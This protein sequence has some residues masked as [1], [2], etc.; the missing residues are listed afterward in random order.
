MNDAPHG[1]VVTLLDGT[2]VPCE[3]AYVGVNDEGVREWETTTVFQIGPGC[4]PPASIT[5][6]LIPP[7]CAIAIRCSDDD[8]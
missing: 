8:R 3:L 1:V 6:A 4:S 5:A 7:G 2:R